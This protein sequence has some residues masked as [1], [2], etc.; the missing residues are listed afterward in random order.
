MSALLGVDYVNTKWVG[1]PGL[2]LEPGP[3]RDT[4][5]ELLNQK[6]C[7]PI[8]LTDET[9]RLYYNG[10]CNNV[11]WP[12][13]H[14][15]PLPLE[16]RLGET[17]ALQLQWEAYRE[18]NEQF[19]RTVLDLYQDG[20]LV[21]CHDYHLLLLPRMLKES[22]PTMKVGWFLHT[23]FPSS[24]IYRT[25][26][27]REEILRGILKADLIG[28][29]T[30][31]YARHF[32]SACTRILG[33]EGTP[34]GVEDR[35]GS[36]ARVS[37]FPIGINSRKFQ[38]GLKLPEV[39]GHMRELRERFAGRK[40]MLG[41][42]RL[43]MIKGI[44]QKLLA[45]EKFL[46]ENPEWTDKVLL[47]QIAVPSRVNVPEYQKLTSEV[48][49]MVGRINGKFGSL[50]SVPIHHLDRSLD[51]HELVALYAITDVALVTSLRDGMNL[52]SFEYIACQQESAG[53]LIMSEF[54]GAA[55]S[56]GAGSLL[57]NPWNVTELSQ[58][59][60]EALNMSEEERWDRHT[61]NF[62]HVTTYTAQAWADTFVSELN[63]TH[64]AASIRTMH[65]PPPLDI[66][67][68]VP[69]F[70]R[71]RQRIL[72]IGYNATLTLPPSSSQRRKR[73]YKEKAVTGMH[74]GAPGIL[75]QLARDPR[76]TVVIISGSE[77]SKLESLFGHLPVWL[78]AENGVYVRAPAAAD[79]PSPEWTMTMENLN[80]GWVESVLPVF[81]YF[82]ERTPRSFVET[83]QFSMMWNFRN[84]DVEFGR[85]QA[86]DLLQHLLT[87]PISSTAVEIFQGTRSVEV[88]PVG[89]TKG[90]TVHHILNA[91]VNS[92]QWNATCEDVGFIMTIGHFMGKDEDI[93]SSIEETCLEPGRT[94]KGL[95]VT[96]SGGRDSSHTPQYSGSF[97]R[98]VSAS[99]YHG[100]SGVQH[101]PAS[102]QQE[103]GPDAADAPSR[104]GASNGAAGEAAASKDRM[105]FPNAKGGCYFC[106]VGRKRSAARYFVPDSNACVDLLSILSGAQGCDPAGGSS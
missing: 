41:V 46:D 60:G 79:A 86:R 11:L 29:H 78:A 43:D 61:T 58:A 33:L 30:Y 27:L 98:G 44:P 97:G 19:A 37:V 24:E 66:P 56:L 28:F 20:D 16:T 82:C 34:E 51:F 18:A 89:V 45:F 48:H 95:T 93:F 77:C 10:Y 22:I 103:R 55:Q 88:R 40:V 15:V 67:K 2:W 52:V 59:M 31:D 73:E 26:P 76:T 14:Y 104:S 105:Y 62:T 75:A 71:S 49:E 42:D 80:M 8:W 4:V 12:L 57:I 13:F 83:R 5:E 68:I 106:T 9:V 50:S 63:D 3:E 36:V 84:A 21:W 100:N 69:Q 70:N 53:V 81:D 72:I 90:A 91:I 1:W 38:E 102:A 25:L 87:G 54:A 99:F 92:G 7:Y 32:V 65:N 74:P 101:A 96:T 23:P 35:E 39:Q 94:P 85:L 47:V 64:I 6:G 17:M